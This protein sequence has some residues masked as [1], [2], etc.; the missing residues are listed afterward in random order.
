LEPAFPQ[1]TSWRFVDASYKFRDEANPY[2]FPEVRNFNDLEGSAEAHFVGIKV[3]DLNGSVVANSGGTAEPREQN[4]YRL[5]AENKK[6]NAGD[7]ISLVLRTDEKEPADGLQLTLQ[8]DTEQLSFHPSGFDPELKHFVG[9]FENEGLLTLSWANA[10]LPNSLFLSLPFRVNKSG[11]TAAM[12]S[13]SDRIT[14]A[15]AYVGG[16]IL[17][18]DIAFPSK[19]ELL[20]MLLSPYPNPFIDQVTIPYFLVTEKLVTLKI[21]DVSGRLV[22]RMTREGRPGKNHFF[23]T[24]LPAGSEW[25]FEMSTDDWKSTGKLISVAR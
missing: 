15:E 8:Y 14:R 11:E 7:Y 17:P 25:T 19:A 23:V 9:V 4:F 20:P 3:G 2:V 18:I 13:V 21:M 1:N 16:K 24:N 22:Q 12:F 6:V 10:L 5:Q